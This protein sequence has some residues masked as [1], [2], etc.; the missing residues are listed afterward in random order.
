MSGLVASNLYADSLAESKEDVV[1]CVVLVVLLST[2]A[3]GV[4]RAHERSHPSCMGRTGAKALGSLAALHACVALVLLFSGGWGPWLSL[5]V[6]APLSAF[7]FRAGSRIVEREVRVEGDDDQLSSSL[8]GGDGDRAPLAHSAH[9]SSSAGTAVDVESG[10]A[11]A[12]TVGSIG[13]E[14]GGGEVAGIDERSPSDDDGAGSVTVVSRGG[15]D[16]DDL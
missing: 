10:T 8:M 6:A 12:P 14:G 2:I 13:S 1:V 9:F 7:W 3:V 16:A 4:Q 5:L 15:I 11:E